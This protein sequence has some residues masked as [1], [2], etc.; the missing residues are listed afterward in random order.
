MN[1]WAIMRMEGLGQWKNLLVSAI[2]DTN[3]D[4][5]SRATFK[6]THMQ[7]DRFGASSVILTYAKPYSSSAFPAFLVVGLAVLGRY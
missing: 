3:A 2:V 7:T 1:F 6:W 5:P 4:E